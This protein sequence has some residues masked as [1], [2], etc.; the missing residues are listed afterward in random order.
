M[1]KNNKSF[2]QLLFTSSMIRTSQRYCC[3]DGSTTKG[4][5]KLII[6]SKKNYD[7]EFL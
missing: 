4:K 6:A 5:N 2:G 1:T 7:T 3:N